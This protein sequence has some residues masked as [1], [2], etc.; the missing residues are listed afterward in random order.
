MK[1][2]GKQR[3]RPSASALDQPKRHSRAI[4]LP[5]E[6]SRGLPQDLLLLLEHMDAP[7]QLAK[8][9]QL[10]ARQSLPLTSIDLG[11][12][13][14][15]AKRLRRDTKLGR[16][17]DDRSTAGGRCYITKRRRVGR[18]WAFGV[19]WLWKGAELDMLFGKPAKRPVLAARRFTPEPHE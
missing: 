3:V 15:L 17:L 5:R 4:G 9:L 11:L 16:G 7:T 6:E 8:L 12:L 10:L 2:V 13:D 18:P 19:S 1:T 14:P